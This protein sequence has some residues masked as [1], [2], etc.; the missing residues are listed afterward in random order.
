M[1]EWKINK[2]MDERINEWKKEESMNEWMDERMNEW[3]NK[4]LVK[5]MIQ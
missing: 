4:W 3:K 1:N 5:S 2:L